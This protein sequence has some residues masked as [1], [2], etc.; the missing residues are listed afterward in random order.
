MRAPTKGSA[1]RACVPAGAGCGAGETRELAC[2]DACTFE[3]ST[4]CVADDA[5]HGGPD[6]NSIALLVPYEGISPAP[7]DWRTLRPRLTS[8]N[9]RV[10]WLDVEDIADVSAQ[11]DEMLVDLGQPPSDRHGIAVAGSVGAA[12]DQVVARVRSIVGL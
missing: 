8:T 10:I 5:I 7:A 12:C 9:T 1:R 3:P 6:P 11:F 4:A 2:N